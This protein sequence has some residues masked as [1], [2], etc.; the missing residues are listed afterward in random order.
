MCYNQI[1]ETRSP[2]Y[3]HIFA[4]CIEAIH[5]GN[6]QATLKLASYYEKGAGCGGPQL[7]AAATLYRHAVIIAQMPK[8]SH[9]L[10]KAIQE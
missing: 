5:M 6:I 1:R 2:K 8:N 4:L 3:K 10:Q 9:C 7:V